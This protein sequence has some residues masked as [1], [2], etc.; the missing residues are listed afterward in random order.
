VTETLASAPVVPQHLVPRVLVDQVPNGWFRVVG[1]DELAIGEVRPVHFF[2][3]E[4]VLWAD[5]AGVPHL[6]DAY[7]PHLGAHFGFGGSVDGDCLQCPFHGWEFDADGACVNIPYSERINKKAK[8]RTYQLVHANRMWLAWFHRDDEPPTWEVPHFPE[9]TDAD[10]TPYYASRFVIAAPPAQMGEN[11]ADP[12]HFPIVH[13]NPALPVMH[14]FA[15]TGPVFS[16]HMGMPLGTS[17]GDEPAEIVVHQYGLGLSTTQFLGSIETLLISTQTPIDAHHTELRFH[18]TLRKFATPEE[19]DGIARY[20]IDE[21]IRQVEGD[22][23]IWEHQHRIERPA[24]ADIDGPILQYRAWT[25]QF[26]A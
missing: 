8:V 14:D 21:T 1:D 13:S 5:S 18:F 10:F 15:V 17:F 25:D 12:A 3:R 23:V 20:F 22:I 2:A 19:T 11:A 6:Q 16:M 26:F 7:C 9:A 4:L 24:L